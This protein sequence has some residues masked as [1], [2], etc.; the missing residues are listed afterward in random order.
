MECDSPKE[1]WEQSW[2]RYI[3]LYRYNSS[4]SRYFAALR[5]HSTLLHVRLAARHPCPM[6]TSISFFSS[7]FFALPVMMKVQGKTLIHSTGLSAARLVCHRQSSNPEVCKSPVVL[8]WTVQLRPLLYLS[9]IRPVTLLLA[10]KAWILQSSWLCRSH[11]DFLWRSGPLIC[12]A[13]LFHV[14][15]QT[16]TRTTVRP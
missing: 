2:Q 11:L 3:Y 14:N 8:F 10:W 16:K 13:R 1:I 15:G 9:E 12:T 5:S 4:R 6:A 7:L